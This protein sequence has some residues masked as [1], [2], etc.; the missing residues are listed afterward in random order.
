MALPL[1]SAKNPCKHIWRESQKQKSTVWMSE[2][3][4]INALEVCKLKTP[5]FEES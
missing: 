5:A 2:Q 3:E 4:F 1:S